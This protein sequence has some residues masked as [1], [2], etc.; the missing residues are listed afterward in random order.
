MA[1]LK[2]VQKHIMRTAFYKAVSDILFILDGQLIK[3]YFP[4][5]SIK[6]IKI[7]AILS[8]LNKILLLY[9]LIFCFSFLPARA[10]NFVD[11]P[12]IRFYY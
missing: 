2:K 10:S 6:Q 7:C 1:E 11:K 5:K 8:F 12:N 4:V 3:R 9:N